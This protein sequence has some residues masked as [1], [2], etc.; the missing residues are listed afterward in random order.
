M[1]SIFQHLKPFRCHKCDRRIDGRSD[2]RSLSWR[3]RP[4]TTL[5]G[6]KSTH[7]KSLVYYQVWVRKFPE[8]HFRRK[9]SRNFR[10]FILI[11]PE[12]Y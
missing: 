3:M 11:F 2:G 1:Q 7:P 12:I 5:R 10:K 9:I 8:I 4:F 6:H